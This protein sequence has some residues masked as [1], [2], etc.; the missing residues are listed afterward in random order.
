MTLSLKVG[1]KVGASFIFRSSVSP[2][3]VGSI[4]IDLQAHKTKAEGVFPSAFGPPP[5]LLFCVGFFLIR[6]LG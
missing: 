3:R 4:Y 5:L 2:H 6:F 1:I